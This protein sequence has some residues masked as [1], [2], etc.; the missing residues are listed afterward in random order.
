MNIEDISHG[1]IPWNKKGFQV[2]N[3]ELSRLLSTPKDDWNLSLQSIS[4]KDLDQDSIEFKPNPFQPMGQI[5]NFMKE[6]YPDKKE[7][8][9]HFFRYNNMIRFL[10]EYEDDLMEEGLIK[11]GPKFHMIKDELL[12]SL[13]VLP[14]TVLRESFGEF[15]DYFYDYDDVVN[16]AWELLR[17]KDTPS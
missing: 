7:F 1:K 3:K 14:F 17:K 6:M 2:V 15:E 16:K 13:C 8:M 11:K 12:D 9:A 10:K 4:L 5:S